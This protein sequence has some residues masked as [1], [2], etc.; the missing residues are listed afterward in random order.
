MEKGERPCTHTQLVP[1][2]TN[3]SLFGGLNW[4]REFRADFKFEPGIFQLMAKAVACLHNYELFHR[5]MFLS[6][7]KQGFLINPEESPNWGNGQQNGRS[8]SV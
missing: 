8:V 3:D 4:I 1:G 7:K 5:M 2:L 6:G